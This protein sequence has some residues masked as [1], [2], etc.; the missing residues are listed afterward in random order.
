V[1]SSAVDLAGLSGFRLDHW[2]FESYSGGNPPTSESMVSTKCFAQ[3]H[4]GDG[5]VPYDPKEVDILDV[6]VS[7]ED[8]WYI[9]PPSKRWKVV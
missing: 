3:R 4:T 2:L 5:I 1:G 6:H 9:I 7:P 8:A